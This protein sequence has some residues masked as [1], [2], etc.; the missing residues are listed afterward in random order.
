M[1]L[2][3]VQDNVN[4]R[5]LHSLFMEIL[6]EMKK[7]YVPECMEEEKAVYS[8]KNFT[9]KYRKDNN[10]AFGL[11]N[12][13]DE[14]CGMQLLYIEGGVAFVEWSAITK[15]ER[16]KKYGK[17]INFLVEQYLSDRKLAHKAFR[18]CLTTNKENI[19]NLISCGYRQIGVVKNFWFN[20]DYYL[21][22]KDL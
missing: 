12:D 17:L 6:E 3:R 13:N 4:L 15:L 14:L 5:K 18:D 9:D 22:E 7:Y 11:Y 20:Q 8:L 1:Q 16:G 10:Y 19:P 2:R 21:W